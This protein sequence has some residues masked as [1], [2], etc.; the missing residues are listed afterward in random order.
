MEKKLFS[1]S[2][3]KDSGFDR[4][5]IFF[6]QGKPSPEEIYL[7]DAG[8]GRQ[9]LFVT[10]ASIF[11][12][13]SMKEFSKSFTQIECTSLCDGAKLFSSGKDLLVVLGSGEKFKT[14]QNVTNIIQAALDHDYNRNCL[15]IAIGGGV[16]CDMTAFAASIYKRGV[17]VEFVPTT[18]LSMVDAAIGGKSGCDYS[19]YKNMI[20]SFWPAKKLH[21]WS[22]FVLSLPDSEYL[23]GLGEALKTALLFSEKLCHIF[24]QEKDKVLARDRDTLKTIIDECA[25]AKAAIVEEDL[26]ERGRRAFLNLGHTFGH[27]LESCAGL[28]TISHGEAVVWGIGR[29]LDLSANLGLCPQEYADTNKSML[30]SYGYDM[31]P[32]PSALKGFNRN[33]TQE[34]IKAMHKDKKNNSNEIRLILQR[35][36]SDTVIQTVSDEEIEKVLK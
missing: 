32:I 31:N 4:T 13:E 36:Y 23:S 5:D 6:Y 9:R 26:R 10:D 11:S 35:N 30:S 3:P 34:L 33:C 29:A 16:I 1:I 2:Y 15:F 27:A 22:D 19:S 7:N 14:L 24:T 12:L 21:V 17:D 18:L 8:D 28:G 25:C 20:G